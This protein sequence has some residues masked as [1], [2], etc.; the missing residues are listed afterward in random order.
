MLK[1]P[2]GSREGGLCLNTVVQFAGIEVSIGYKQVFKIG[3]RVIDCPGEKEICFVYSFFGF[4]LL[5]LLGKRQ[6]HR[7]YTLP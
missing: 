5:S 3:R 7:N 2:Q 4:S 6:A 1:D